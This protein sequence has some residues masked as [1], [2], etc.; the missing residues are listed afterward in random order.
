MF[1]QMTFIVKNIIVPT[2]PFLSLENKKNE[3]GDLDQIKKQ[4]IKAQK[5]FQ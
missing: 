1:N 5:A 3:T 2:Y 4:Q